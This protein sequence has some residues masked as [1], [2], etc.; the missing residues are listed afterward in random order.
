MPTKHLV[1]YQPPIP[2]LFYKGLTGGKKDGRTDDTDRAFPNLE[3]EG[4]PE[5][6]L[7]AAIQL[8]GSP[9]ATL[10]DVHLL[11]GPEKGS[12]S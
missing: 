12:E 5:Q 10:T 4:D 8:R 9:N 7:V 3:R 6:I 11:Q 2:W 1:D